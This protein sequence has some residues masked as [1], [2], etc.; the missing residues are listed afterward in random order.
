MTEEIM[1]DE[2]LD[3]VTGGTLEECN[4]DIKFLSKLGLKINSE[5]NIEDQVR[6]GWSS[7]VMKI[8]RLIIGIYIT[9]KKFHAIKHT[10][11]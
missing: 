3:E 11:L 7:V 4:K 9:T 5:L 8:L 6:Y 10:E 2:E 1:S